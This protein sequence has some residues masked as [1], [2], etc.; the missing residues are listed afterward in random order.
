M[1]TLGDNLHTIKPYRDQKLDISKF[2]IDIDIIH[3]LK[4]LLYYKIE[5]A[6]LITY[7]YFVSFL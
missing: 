2:S 4:T 7:W 3:K 6:R 5:F 1:L